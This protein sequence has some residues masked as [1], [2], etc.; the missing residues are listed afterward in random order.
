MT[1]GPASQAFLAVAR[2]LLIEK[3][4]ITFRMLKEQDMDVFKADGVK[5]V[6]LRLE[7]ERGAWHHAIS[8]GQEISLHVCISVSWHSQL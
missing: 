5:Q 4:Q 7:T 1:Q 3:D 6:V 2:L 8:E